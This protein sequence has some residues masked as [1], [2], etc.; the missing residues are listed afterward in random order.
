M[1]SW[2]VEAELVAAGF[3][4]LGSGGDSGSPRR[5]QPE[6]ASAIVNAAAPAIDARDNLV[7]G[8]KAK[9]RMLGRTIAESRGRAKAGRRESALSR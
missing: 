5:P 8:I 2:V 1:A 4:A 6:S 3:G 7:E 9:L